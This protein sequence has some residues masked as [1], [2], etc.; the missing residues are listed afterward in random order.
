[1][2]RSSDDFI[3][4][5]AESLKRYGIQQIVGAHCTG[6]R[7]AQLLAEALGITDANLSHGAVGA[8]VTSDLKIVR[9][10]VE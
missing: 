6:I 2:F 7:A 1:M 5:T 10:S 8:V 9:S 4:N 3:I